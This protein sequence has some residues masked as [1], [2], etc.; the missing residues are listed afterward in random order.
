M[1]DKT[2]HFIS[3]QWMDS[4]AVSLVTTTNITSIGTVKRQVGANSVEVPCP[5]AVIQYQRTM[6]G[7]DKGDQFRM[8]GGGFSNKAHFKKWYKKTY[9]AMLDCM[10]MNATL[11]WNMAVK[12]DSGKFKLARHEFMHVIAQRMMEYKD[13]RTRAA[14]VPTPNSQSGNWATEHIMENFEYGERC[15][16]CKLEYNMNKCLRQGRMAKKVV[17]YAKSRAKIDI[18][19]R[20]IC[21]KVVRLNS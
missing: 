4:K 11:A 15:V 10:L 7:V 6:F 2:N 12:E 9:L 5:D 1:A 14:H 20:I 19:Q 3:V 17:H 21:T 16:V 13:E 8:H 18:E